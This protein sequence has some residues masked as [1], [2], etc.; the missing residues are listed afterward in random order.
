[1]AKVDV[2][3]RD[4]TLEW[5]RSSEYQAVPSREITELLHAWTHGDDEALAALTPLVHA[6]LRS[7]ARALMR[8]ERPGHTL[9]PTGLVNECFLRLVNARDVDWQSRT[10]FFAL[11]ARLMRRILVD[12]ARAHK[13]GKRGG[14]AIAV[15]L[16]QEANDVHSPEPSRDLVALDDA[17]EALASI[18]ERKSQ[19]VEMRFF[20]GLSNDEIA[21]MLGVSAKTVTR[22]WQLA[23]VW[24]WRELTRD[25]GTGGT[26]R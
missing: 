23:R 14:G 20:G 3:E 1:M 15:T 16:D 12:F 9:Q 26:P 6:E 21:A 19:V 7:R 10:H 4:W 17:L 25:D 24:L 2:S 22:D 5:A 11:S 18:D 13:H 8:A